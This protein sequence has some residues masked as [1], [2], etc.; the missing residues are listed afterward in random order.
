LLH[1]EFYP[2]EFGEFL[3]AIDNFVSTNLNPKIKEAPYEEWNR[4]FG[5]IYERFA[6]N[7]WSV[8]Q[9]SDDGYILLGKIAQNPWAEIIKI[10]VNG[11]EQ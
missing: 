10:D 4:S 7:V 8:Q 11:N 5:G 6:D 3:T 2:A 9:T 1:G